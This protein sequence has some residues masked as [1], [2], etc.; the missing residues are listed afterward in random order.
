MKLS[1]YGQPSWYVAQRVDIM[2]KRKV[3]KEKKK[4]SRGFLRRLSSFWRKSEVQSCI[5]QNTRSNSP[6]YQ[7]NR[8]LIKCSDAVKSNS[9]FCLQKNLRALQLSL[10]CSVWIGLRFTVHSFDCAWLVLFE[11]SVLEHPSVRNCFWRHSP[12]WPWTGFVL[13]TTHNFNR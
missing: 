2:K 10:K 1:E 5:L 3:K 7:R 11:T 6:T 4:K 9:F 8:S 13:K 12:F